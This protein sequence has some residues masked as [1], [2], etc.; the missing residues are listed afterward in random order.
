[1]WVNIPSHI[2]RLSS[3]HELHAFLW[4]L[5]AAYLWFR[6]DFWLSSKSITVLESPRI[7]VVRLGMTQT[8]RIITGDE[9]CVHSH[10]TET[11]QQYSQCRANIIVVSFHLLTCRIWLPGLQMILKL[12]CRHF[13]TVEEI[14]CELQIVLYLLT[15]RD[16]K[17]AF[18]ASFCRG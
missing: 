10:D 14:H 2:A 17:G 9:S 7:S 18:Q 6:R 4:P 16:F 8:S 15:E 1:M 11:T 13:E 3:A 12:K 5:A